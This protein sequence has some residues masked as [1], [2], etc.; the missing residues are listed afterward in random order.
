MGL[1]GPPPT[2]KD[3]LDARGSWRAKGRKQSRPAAGVPVKPKDLPP[4]ATA[5][6]EAVVP[7]LRRAGW[8]G[9]LDSFALEQA[10][11]TWGLWRAAMVAAERDPTS[12]VCRAAVI[13]Y[14]G[15]W[16]TLAAKLGLTPA[17]R[18]RLQLDL[19]DAPPPDDLDRY[20][21]PIDGSEQPRRRTL[22]DFKL[23][24]DPLAEF[25]VP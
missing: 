3:A 2:P 17:D 12:K 25:K 18:Q 23:N 13:A 14:S 15:L 6:W 22:A 5:F 16:L 20:F 8:A 1:R 4:A 24:R 21:R 10:A 9:R 19:A 7:K 11:R